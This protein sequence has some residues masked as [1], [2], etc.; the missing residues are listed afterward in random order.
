MFELY[1]E[2]DVELSKKWKSVIDTQDARPIAEHDLG[3]RYGMARMLENTANWLKTERGEGGMLFN[4]ATPTTV[5]A[6]VSKWDP[7]ILS[8]VRRMGP[9]LLGN[10]LVGV[11]PMNS[12]QG[13]V[14]ALRPRYKNAAGA[15]IHKTAP[16]AHF[17]GLKS[18][19]TAGSA[20]SDTA[21]DIETNP[22]AVVTPG[23]PLGNAFTTGTAM[24]TATGE[25]DIAAE[26]SMTVDKVPVSAK[27]RALKASYSLETAQ[28]LASQHGISADALFT[29]LLSDQL[30]SET[31]YEILRTLYRIAVLGCSD[32]AT[33]GVYDLDVDCDGRW[34][35]EK[36]RILA[37]RIINEA[38]EIMVATRTGHG[39][40]AVVD[41]KTYN[42]LYSGGQISDLGPSNNMFSGSD[43]VVR[44]NNVGSGMLMGTLRVYRD[45]YATMPGNTGFCLIGYKGPSELDA[46]AFYTPYVPVW[47]VRVNDQDSGQPRIFF[48]TRYGLVQ[49]PLTD[50]NGALTARSNAFYRIFR[51]DSLDF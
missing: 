10:Q 46:G 8:M 11:Q 19:G 45:D 33:P 35:A 39:N 21:S 17:T 30:A 12:P 34:L 31:N 24:D 6:N 41:R 37:V 44:D 20:G 48:K 51:I 29:G 13:L 2:Q 42:L 22:L 28:D 50:T 43:P 14:F 36:A 38:S 25:G 32:T 18:G 49:N 15:E 40:F 9:T 7:I 27:T 47:T 26:I 4:E 3:T 1:N 16:K 23:D 5:T